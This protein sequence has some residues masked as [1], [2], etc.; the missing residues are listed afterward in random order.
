MPA[1]TEDD[2]RDDFAPRSRRLLVGFGR[3]LRGPE[4]RSTYWLTR[5]VFLRGL[6]LVY[7]V[8]F[9]V[10]AFQLVPLIGERGLLPVGSY[11]ARLSEHFGSQREAFLNLPSI[12]WL[13]HSDATLLAVAIV[14]ATLSA[15]VL[16]GLSNAGVLLL[17]WALYLSIDHVGQRWYSFG[18]ETQLLETG[19]IAVFLCPLLGWRPRSSRHPP[20]IVPIILLRWLIVR[21]MLGAGLIK[22]RGDP[23]WVELTCLETHFE[24]QPIPNPL[25]PV[26]HLMPAWVLR[27]GV[28]MNHITELLA[29][30]F[31][32]GPRRMR[33]VAGALMIAFQLVLIV[34]GNLSFLNWLTILPCIAC[35][36]DQLLLRLLPSR[37]R[38]RL[39]AEQLARARRPVAAHRYLT[40][41]F[42]ALVAYLSLPVVSNL[43]GRGQAM[44]RSYDR[45]HIV[46]TYGAFGSVGRTRHELVIEGTR[47][48]LDDPFTIEDADW[49]EYEFKCKPGDPTRRP[50]VITPY[51]YRLDWLIWFAALEVEGRGRLQREDWVLHLV[52]KLLMNDAGARALMGPSP[53]PEA[54]PRYIRVLFYRYE[55]APWGS[56]RWWERERVGVVLPPIAVD[57]PRLLDYLRARGWGPDA[58]P[59]PRES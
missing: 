9:L 52:Y 48:P 18:W 39:E 13:D 42:A 20:P 27:G 25:S 30:L 6:G 40:Y 32:F 1:A 58:K 41:A 17:L 46:N 47:D 55:F 4:V 23:C 19:L 28:L 57:D 21:I 34:S 10:A 54:P 22:L 31:A 37:W 45:L 2:A 5:Q 44:N 49:R 53:F 26:L 16:L 38:A 33:H 29:P 56:G 3:A 36:D 7:L 50:C 11:L 24:T 8:A 59:E 35:F 12:F 15:A 43:L 14:G 51:H